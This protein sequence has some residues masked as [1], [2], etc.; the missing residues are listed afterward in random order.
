MDNYP[1]EIKEKLIEFKSLGDKSIP[2]WGL[3]KEIKNGQG[4]GSWI[5]ARRSHYT[6]P[7]AA[8]ASYLDQSKK[9][10]NSDEDFYIVVKN[11]LE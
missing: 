7:M 5:G 8:L 10:F 6:H 3:V 11:F 2:W 1:D 4:P 9:D